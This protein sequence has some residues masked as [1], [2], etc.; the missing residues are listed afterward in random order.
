MWSLSKRVM[1]GTR[2]FVA[3]WGDTRELQEVQSTTTGSRK[4]QV[5]PS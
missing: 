4:L 1:V 5:V 2:L 3:I